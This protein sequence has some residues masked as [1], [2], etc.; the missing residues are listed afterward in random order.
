VVASSHLTTI[1]PFSFGA[2]IS[3]ILDV[4]QDFVAQVNHSSFTASAT[5]TTSAA[6]FS[7]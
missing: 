7:S 6:P 5:L 4:V 1:S 3:K 2:R